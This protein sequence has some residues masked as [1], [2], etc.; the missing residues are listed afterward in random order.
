[1]RKRKLDANEIGTILAALRLFQKEYDRA[2]ARPIQDDWPDQFEDCLP[3]NSEC[4][5]TLCEHINC[6]MVR[7]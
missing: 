4:I 7:L 6:R 5:D 3:L 2:S 1:M